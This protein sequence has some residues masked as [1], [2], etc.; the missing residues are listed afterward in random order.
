M[1]VKISELPNFE[2]ANL[3]ADSD[4]VFPVVSD[5]TSSDTTFKTT[6]ANVKSYIETGNLNVTGAF[7]ASADSVIYG[8]L[9]VDVLTANT[10]VIGTTTTVSSSSNFVD[11]QTDANVTY[12][13]S[14]N[15]LDVGIR[16]F[17]YKGAANSS[18]L[19]WKNSNSVLTWYGEEVGN[20]NT[21]ISSA[22]VL[23]AMEVGSLVV[24]NATA[25]TANATGALQIGGGTS[26]GGNLWVVGRANIGGTL[27]AGAGTLTSLDAGAGSITT[28]GNAAVG[29]IAVTDRI[30]GASLGLTSFATIASTLV[31]Q[32]NTTV[33]GLTVNTSGVVNNTLQAKGGLQNTP[34]GNAAASSGSFTSLTAAAGLQN[35]PVGNATAASGRFTTLVTTST[36]TLGGF[37]Q[38]TGNVNPTSNATFDLGSITAQW[39]DIYSAGN[40]TAFATRALYADLAEK[41]IPDQ[42]Y[43]PG[44]VVVFGGEKEITVTDKREDTRV[45]GV[46]STQPAYVMNDGE[47]DGIPIALRGKV[48]VK[49]IGFVNKGDLLVTSEVPGYAA[50]AHFG[51]P[52]ANAVFAKSLEQDSSTERRVIWAVIV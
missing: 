33:N 16:L 49:V 6:I 29:N 52:H 34:I 5:Y 21:T 2:V 15:G 20:T 4:T 40:I 35:T 43:D 50:A 24:G 10:Q 36:A 26:M 32:A 31:V 28:T 23:G 37:T 44:T 12:P 14:D 47:Q 48:P 25:T 9:T 27:N 18:A 38:V 41:Y 8:N 17:W 11:I 19:V 46:V 39:R 51:V 42:M 1:S 45:A 7:S 3:I 13:I 22:A 30:T